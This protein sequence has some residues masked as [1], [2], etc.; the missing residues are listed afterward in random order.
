MIE[1]SEIELDRLR[2]LVEASCDAMRGAS[3][4]AMKAPPSRAFGLQYNRIR[5]EA[6]RLLPHL[7]GLIPPKVAARPEDDEEDARYLEVRVYLAQL[8]V[9]LTPAPEAPRPAAAGT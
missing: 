5:G 2:R 9:L 6:E 4:R 1:D 7:A 8:G 3:P